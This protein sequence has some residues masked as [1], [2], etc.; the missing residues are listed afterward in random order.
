MQ[1]RASTPEH[2]RKGSFLENAW[3]GQKEAE[4]IQVESYGAQLTA[5]FVLEFGLISYSFLLGMTLAV[6]AWSD[7]KILHVVLFFLPNAGRSRAWRAG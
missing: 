4:G 5:I 1:I 6:A 7:F 3:H 2:S